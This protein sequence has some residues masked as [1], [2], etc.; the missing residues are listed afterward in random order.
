MY[1]LYKGIFIFIAVSYSY[2]LRFITTDLVM[3]IFYILKGFFD[4]ELFCAISGKEQFYKVKQANS[5]KEK[6]QWITRVYEYLEDPLHGKIDWFPRFLTVI[7]LRRYYGDCVAEYEKIITERGNIPIKDLN[8]NDKVLSYNFN[9]KKY[10][11]KEIL[12]HVNKG[13]KNIV[14]VHYKTGN[15]SDFTPDHKIYHGNIDYKVSKIKDIDINNHNER[16]VPVIT[17]MPYT[18]QDNDYY[19]EDICFLLGYYMAEGYYYKKR[20]YIGGHDIPKY[21]IPILDKYD[22]KY[23]LK[24]REG[25]NLPIIEFLTSDFRNN[26]LGEMVLNSFNINPPKILY[27]LPPKKLQKILDGYFLGDGHMRENKEK[28]Y[29][30]SC[31]ILKDFIVEISFK[32]GNPVAPYHQLKHGGV[33][34]KPIWRIY[35][36]PKAFHKKNYG[37]T[38]LSETHIKKIE[39]LNDKVNVYDIEVKDNHNF[40]MANSGVIVHNCDDFGILARYMYG[41]GK[42]YSILPYNKKYWNRMHVVYVRNNKIY[43]SDKIYFMSL[44]EYL[45]RYY[46]SIDYFKLKVI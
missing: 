23:S 44:Q 31:D 38:N 24:I 15:Y 33:G 46:N 25:D 28:C 34:N 39:N 20:C 27:N 12:N 41:D 22:I 30:T 29:S 32:I 8:K 1:T 40:I 3:N 16:K 21:I 13:K 5:E 26:I 10:E 17:K 4:G 42:L 14:R 18:I 11:F 6:D 7:I 19:T 45:D 2:F 37:Y 9:L 43:S 35:D 36:R